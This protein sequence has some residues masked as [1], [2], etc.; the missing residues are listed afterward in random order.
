MYLKY[1]KFNCF[2]LYTITDKLIL[3]KYIINSMVQLI[4]V[5]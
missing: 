4:V 1:V 5:I 3:K 2:Q